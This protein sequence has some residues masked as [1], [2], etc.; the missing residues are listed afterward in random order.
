MKTI[1]V[2]VTEAAQNLSDYVNRAHYE[3]TIF[4]LLKNGIPFARL[5]PGHE[6]VCFGRD[7]AK[8]LENGNLSA[9]A[10]KAWRGD[11][12]AARKRLKTPVN[13]WR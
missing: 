12:H 6:K 9:K 2:N 3:N 1:T 5:T 4:V 13:R 11:L 8:A 10:A 7:L